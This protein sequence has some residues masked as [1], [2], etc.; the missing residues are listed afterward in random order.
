MKVIGVIGILAAMLGTPLLILGGVLP[1][2]AV[3]RRAAL[4][5]YPWLANLLKDVAPQT[6]LIAGIALVAG[7]FLA[8]AFARIGLWMTNSK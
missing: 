2:D 1:A 4:E 3:D 5:A 6:L 8:L 7:G